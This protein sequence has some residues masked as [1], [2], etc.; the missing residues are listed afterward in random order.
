MQ[1]PVENILFPFIRFNFNYFIHA[2]KIVRNV[3]M[4]LP[5]E[6]PERSNQLSFT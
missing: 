2:A 3:W 6:Q 1:C 4:H 5:G